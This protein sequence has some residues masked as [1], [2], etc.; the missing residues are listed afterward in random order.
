[1]VGFLEDLM[2]NLFIVILPLFLYETYWLSN[3]EKQQKHLVLPWLAFAVSLVLSM[4]FPIVLNDNYFFDLR[5]VPLII[6]FLYFGYK[7]GL[8]LAV[9]L[10]IV[11]FL[12]GGDGF[13]PTLFVVAVLLLALSLISKHYSLFTWKKKMMTSL[14]LSVLIPSAIAVYFYPKGILTEN[15]SAILFVLFPGMTVGISLS[16]LFMERINWNVWMTANQTSSE[17]IVSSLAASTSH[18]VRNPLT[19]TRGFIQFLRHPDLSPEVK[20]KYIQIALQELDRAEAI[21]DDYLSIARNSSSRKQQ[22]DAGHELSY[23]M[24]VIK[25]LANMNNVEIHASPLPSL[26]IKA[27]RKSFHQCFI[28]L[29]KNCIEA[30][31]EGGIL[32]M[33][34]EKFHRNIA[35]T[36]CDTGFGMTQEQIARIGQPY[37][38][39]KKK[40]T[41]LGM[42]VVMNVIKEMGGTLQ[43]NSQPGEGTEFTILLPVYEP[44][45]SHGHNK[46]ASTSL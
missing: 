40:G 11:R 33:R 38:T 16:T 12:M 3:R 24:N 9:V 8:L 7:T 28:N 18:E 21:I 5:Y 35:I 42:V 1:M 13:Y 26:P 30:M 22:L 46:M 6:G 32:T 36:I 25:P 31:P 43:I 14:L 23:V 44:K 19:V 37:F 39:T 4:S 34:L 27:E 17:K 15:A 2:I 10:L 20:E 41:G 45:D 29:V